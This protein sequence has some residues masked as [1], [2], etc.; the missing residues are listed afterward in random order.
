MIINPSRLCLKTLH[1]LGGEY[2]VRSFGASELDEFIEPVLHSPVWE[3]CLC[4]VDLFLS[5]ITFISEIMDRG[6]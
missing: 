5:R 1:G 2:L 3:I 4:A 6:G